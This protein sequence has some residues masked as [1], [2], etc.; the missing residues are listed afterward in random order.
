MER[1]TDFT[2]RLSAPESASDLDLSMPP[3]GL[4]VVVDEHRFDYHSQLEMTPENSGIPLVFGRFL[5][6]SIASN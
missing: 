3:D 4:R 2:Q 6:S 5:R 1:L